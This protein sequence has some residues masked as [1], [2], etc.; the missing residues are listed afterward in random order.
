MNTNEDL[1]KSSAHGIVKKLIISLI[2]S[3][4][5][6]LIVTLAINLFMIIS[7]EKSIFTLGELPDLEI[8]C[9]YALVLGCHVNSS[10][11]PSTMLEHRLNVGAELY[12]SSKVKKIIV[13]GNHTDEFSNEPKVMKEYLVS[14]GVPEEDILKDEYG[15]STYD[16]VKHLKDKFSAKSVV[17]VSQKYHL[18]RAMHIAHENGITVYGASATFGKYDRE[19][20][21]ELRE[22]AARCKDAFMTA[23]NLPPKDGTK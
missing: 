6:V 7:F 19:F 4:A 17:I 11:T 13:S 5:A 12:F 23:F 9:E 10:G 8:Q 20:Y 16:S 22:Y 18:Y 14:L 15:F 3:A 21:Y 1:K 2:I